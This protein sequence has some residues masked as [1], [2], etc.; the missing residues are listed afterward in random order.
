MSFAEDE[1]IALSGIQHFAF[2]KRQWAL[3]HIERQWHENLRTVQGRQLHERV[4]NPNFFEARGEILTTRAVPI[5]S[6]EL[7]FYGVADVVEF[8]LTDD[9][10]IL[11]RGRKGFWKL[12]P[13]EYKR[14]K[15][16]KSN[17]DEVQ[18]CAQTICLEEMFYTTIEHGYIY[19]GEIKHRTKVDFTN[20]LRNDVVSF[21]T[22]MRDM[23]D[24]KYTPKAKKKDKT[25]RS[26][27]LYDLCLPV[28]SSKQS[29]AKYING[30][31]NEGE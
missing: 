16:K 29:V 15:P 21:A 18:L 31:L 2:C 26:C 27:S 11:L 1:L 14:G 8:H 12:I 22:Q 24:R 25:C 17:V 28:L 19:Y 7:G 3:I 20:E 30:F 13:I 9:N 4:D 6:Y 23:F 5:V 10:G